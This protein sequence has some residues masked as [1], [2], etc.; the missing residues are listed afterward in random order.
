MRSSYLCPNE[1]LKLS[2]GWG[3]NT[4]QFALVVRAH[5]HWK[6]G[7]QVLGFGFLLCPTKS[8]FCLDALGS[9]MQSSET[10]WLQK[11]LGWHRG[12]SG[13][14]VRATMLGIGRTCLKL[15]LVSWERRNGKE[16]RNYHNDGLCMDS[17]K[18]PFL[19]S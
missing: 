4:A 5:G 19:H 1:E 14:N 13:E 11:A 2:G 9:G 6:I 12:L 3:S 10:C 15:S 7:E 17:Y 18:D 16:N 8:A